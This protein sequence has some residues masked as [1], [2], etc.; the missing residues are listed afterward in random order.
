MTAPPDLVLL[1]VPPDLAEALLP[2]SYADA[3]PPSQGWPS[4]AAGRRDFSLVTLGELPR[5]ATKSYDTS[6]LGVTTAGVWVFVPEPK[7][8]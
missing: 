5:P 8:V 6:F 1:R 2:L 4:S 7:G 3:R